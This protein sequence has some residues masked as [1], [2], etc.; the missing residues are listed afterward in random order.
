[1]VSRPLGYS[2][3]RRD[4]PETPIA[5][6]NTSSCWT[7]AGSGTIARIA[8]FRVTCPNGH[9]HTRPSRLEGRITCPSCHDTF[10]EDDWDQRVISGEARGCYDCHGRGRMHTA[11]LLS[12]DSARAVRDALTDALGDAP[13]PY[14]ERCRCGR[15][16]EE[17][18][19]K[20]DRC[21]L[22]VAS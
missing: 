17:R 13:V 9:N 5:L 8:G 21:G 19:G 10:P 3:E 20:C 18:H 4:D 12:E 22:W 7:C 6:L 2:V 14:A 16:A 11:A 15:N 1:V